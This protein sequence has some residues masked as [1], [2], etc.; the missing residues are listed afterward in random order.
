MQTF[1]VGN[2]KTGW[3]YDTV[4]AANYFFTF[5]FKIFLKSFA[6][7]LNHSFLET[8]LY[9]YICYI[10]MLYIAIQLSWLNLRILQFR[11]LSRLNFC[12]PVPLYQQSLVPTWII[13]CAV[14]FYCMG[15]T[16]YF[17]PS[18]FAPEKCFTN[19]FFLCFT[20]FVIALS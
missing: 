16:K 9:N 12:S 4:L 18:I 3:Y 2:D 11:W 10:Y 19:T 5:I 13:I 15:F 6:L 7:L 8:M 20:D 14:C 17:I 1:C